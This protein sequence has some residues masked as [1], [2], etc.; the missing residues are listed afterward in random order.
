MISEKAGYEI[1]FATA[2]VD[3]IKNYGDAWRLYR[4]SKL[5]CAESHMDHSCR[6]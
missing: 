1:G 5:F 2:A 3:W 4:F 6:R